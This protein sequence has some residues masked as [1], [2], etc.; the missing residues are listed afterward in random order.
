VIGN[1]IVD[2][3]QAEKDSNWR[4]PG[5]L[6][7]LFTTGEQFLISAVEVPDEMV[8]LLWTMKESAYKIMSREQKLRTFAP[9]KLVCSN[10]ILHPGSAEGQVSYAEDCYFTKSTMNAEYI[11][12]VATRQKD[13][14]PKIQISISAYHTGY[15]HAVNGSVSHHGRYLALTSL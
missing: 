12:T 10:L 9:A 5:Y 2:L 1:D 14:L 7:K 15:L 11:H 13:D 8:W 4:R 3:K 6:N